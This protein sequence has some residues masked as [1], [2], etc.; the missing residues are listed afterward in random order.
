MHY[1]LILVADSGLVPKDSSLRQYSEE[2]TSEGIEI[3]DNIINM[4]GT[5]REGTV[6]IG[7]S[8]GVNIVPNEVAR[9]AMEAHHEVPSFDYI[10]R[11]GN[12]LHCVLQRESPSRDWILGTDDGLFVLDAES[13]PEHH[14]HGNG[15][16][17]SPQHSARRISFQTDQ[18]PASVNALLWTADHGLLIGT[19]NGLIYMPAGVIST[20]LEDR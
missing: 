8:D 5:D 7:T 6:W 20:M 4:I 3:R 19:T 11:K 12:A 1:P 17:P 16:A 18:T 10:G 2:I 9:H 14:E 15:D 13:L